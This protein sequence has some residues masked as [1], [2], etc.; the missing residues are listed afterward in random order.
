MTICIAYK[1]REN[2][3]VICACDSLLLSGQF[4]IGE[5]YEEKMFTKNGLTYLSA[6]QTKLKH[7]LKYKF[8]GETSFFLQPHTD[9][10]VL[11]FLNT[12]YIDSLKE[13]AIENKMVDENNLLN[14]LPIL[15]ANGK[16]YKTF[17]DFSICESNRDYLCI[18]CSES[19]AYGALYALENDK[20]KSIKEKIEIAINAC[21]EFSSGCDNRIQWVVV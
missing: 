3:R 11:K 21:N 19:I 20:T 13:F 1:D 7:L 5:V 18:G 16:I 9:D 12:D 10:E 6:G 15:I 14:I 2:D 17:A 8:K 4:D